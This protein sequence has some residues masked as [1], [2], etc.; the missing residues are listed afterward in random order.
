MIITFLFVPKVGLG[1]SLQ[2]S[3][4]CCPVAMYHS[5][6]HLS[7]HTV[8]SFGAPCSN[9]HT[10]VVGVT[11]RPCYLIYLFMVKEIMDIKTREGKC[12]KSPSRNQ[13]PSIGAWV[14][15]PGLFA[16][17]LEQHD[18]SSS[19]EKDCS[20]SSY[21]G[22][23]LAGRSEV[24]PASRRHS[25]CPLK[26]LGKVNLSKPIWCPQAMFQDGFAKLKTDSSYF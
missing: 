12:I 22:A 6:E 5:T 19:A 7:S 25:F 1:H 3:C 8:T 16:A 4:L 20:P 18:I 9:F 2:M 24:W 21:G 13:L 23:S 26:A 11:S 14:H 15:L 10:F 17:T